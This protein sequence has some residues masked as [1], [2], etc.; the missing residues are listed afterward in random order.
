MLLRQRRNWQLFCGLHIS[1]G[2]YLNHKTPFLYRTG[3]VLAKYPFIPLQLSSAFPQHRFSRFLSS[4]GPY[5]CQ[6]H[7]LG[8]HHKL[9]IR[10]YVVNKIPRLLFQRSSFSGYNSTFSI[11]R[12]TIH[13]DNSRAHGITSLWR[14]KVTFPSVEPAVRLSHSSRSEKLGSTRTNSM[15]N[16]SANHDG[17]SSISRKDEQNKSGVTKNTSDEEDEVRDREAMKGMSSSQK[18]KYMLTRY[19]RFAA[20][21]YFILGLADLSVYYMAISMGLDVQ[22]FLDSIFTIFGGS[23]GWISPKYSNLIAAYS[24]HKV[25]TVPRVLF[26]A[27]TTP[28]IVRRIKT[29]YPRLYAKLF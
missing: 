18:F 11:Q 23:P 15:S 14:S 25:M 13:Y 17:S 16:K 12:H 10:Q 26:V 4:L 7:L 9:Y 6:N 29:S 20:M 19:G 28:S 24:V 22:P 21:Y 1:L 8:Y 2:R 3:S 5:V 27:S